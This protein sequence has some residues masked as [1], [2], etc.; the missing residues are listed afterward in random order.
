MNV[1]YGLLSMICMSRYPT[2][3]DSYFLPVAAALTLIRPS[4]TSFTVAWISEKSWKVVNGTFA[5][6]QYVTRSTQ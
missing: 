4:T 1:V 3:L 5:F 6:S 2:D